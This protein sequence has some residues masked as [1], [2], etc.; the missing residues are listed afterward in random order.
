MQVKARSLLLGIASFLPVARNFV[1]GGTGGTV[2][3][4]YCYSV[5]LRHL[6]KASAR[7]GLP[8]TVAEL[9]PG[10]SLGIGLAAMLSSAHR[11]FALD[12][13]EHARLSKNAEILEELIELFCARAPIPGDEEFPLV[14]PK[15]AD[16]CFPKQI[17]GEEHLRATLS[18]KRLDAIRAALHGRGRTTSG[19]DIQYVAPWHDARQLRSGEVDFIFSQ[20]VLE[21]V[22]DLAQTYGALFNWLRPGGL[23]SH[24]IDFR[25][26][27]LTRDWNGHWAL[28]DG[29]WRIVKGTRPYLINRHPYSVHRGALIAA[30][31]M[32]N[33]EERRIAPALGRSQLA[34]RYSALSDADLTTSGVYLQATKPL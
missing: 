33:A 5:W 13:V 12:V 25:S 30:G 11:Y 16:Y 8:R 31:F 26:H 7:N 32:L 9:G 6:V 3:A 24:Q 21:H 15:L 18:G 19:I 34:R 23:M 10:D 1:C 20:A 27:G 29:M 14:Y 2:S 28:S 4:R 17:L 22:E